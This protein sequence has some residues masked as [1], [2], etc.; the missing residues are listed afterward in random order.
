D[1]EHQ[2]VGIG[3]VDRAAVAMTSVVACADDHGGVGDNRRWLGIFDQRQDSAPSHFLAS[4]IVDEFPL[5]TADGVGLVFFDG[6]LGVGRII[7]IPVQQDAEGGIGVRNE[8]VH[9]RSP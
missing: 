8:S 9:G 3:A 6:H 7:G 4:S 1:D 2:L 5:M